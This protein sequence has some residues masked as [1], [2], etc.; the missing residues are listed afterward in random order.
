MTPLPIGTSLLQG[1]GRDVADMW[2]KNF[3]S[4]KCGKIDQ[5][6]TC[7]EIF[8]HLV[9]KAIISASLLIVLCSKVYIYLPI[10]AALIH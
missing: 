1:L 2:G 8:S 4:C 5:V 10:V 9:C 7:D 6:H 3:Q